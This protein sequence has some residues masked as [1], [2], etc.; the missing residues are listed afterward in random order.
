[1][2]FKKLNTIGGWISFVIALIVYTATVESSV[3]LWDC[4]EFIS[5]AYKLQVVHPPGA[6]LFLMIGRVFSFLAFGNVENVAFWINMLSVISSAACVMFTF[7]ITTHFAAKMVKPGEDKR[8]LIILAAGAVAALTN[9]FID[10]FWFSAVEAEVYALSSFFTALSFWAL[11]KWDVSESK[12]ADRWLVFIAYLVGLALGTHMLNLLII[13]VVGIAYYF[14]NSAKKI[15]MKGAFKALVISALGLGIVMKLIYPGIPWLVSRMDYFFVNTLSL[16]FY[17]GAL[18]SIVFIAALAIFL[19]K[20]TKGKYT[21]NLVVL[22]TL[23]VVL[24]YSSYSMVIIRSLANPTIDMNDPEDP[25][26]FYGYITREQYGDRPLAYGPYFNSQPTATEPKGKKVF[27]S[28]SIYQEGEERFEYVY[29]KISPVNGQNQTTIF[30]RMGGT[31]RPNDEIGYRSWSGMEDVT[32]EIQI[33]Q[34]KANKTAQDQEEIKYLESQLPSF[35]NNLSFFFNYQLGHMYKRYFFWN[36]V[37]RFNNQ[38]GM[39][40]SDLDGAWYSGTPIDNVFGVGSLDGLPKAMKKQKARNAYYF[41][42]FILGLIGLYLHFKKDLKGFWLVMSLFLFTG[43]ILIVYLNPPP[44][45]PRE[46]DY[47]LVGSFQTFCIWVGLG[48][49]GVIQFLRKYLKGNAAIAG[50][51][52]CIL[53]VPVNMGYQNWDDHDRSGR[54]IGKNSAQNFLNNLEPNAVLICNGDNDTYPL[55]YLQ[56]VEGVRTDVR[57]INMSLLPTEWYSSVLLDKVMKSEPL[58]MTLTKK[59]L[60]TGS[61]ENG[62]QINRATKGYMDID[63]A[64]AKVLETNKAGSPVWPSPYISIPTYKSG[65][66]E[67]GIVSQ[68]DLEKAVDTIRFGIGKSYVTKGDILLYNYIAENAKSGWKRPLYFTAVSGYNFNGLNDYLQLEGLVYKFVPVNGGRSGS[69]PANVNREKLYDNLV[70][71]YKYYG[72]KEN[73]NFFL[74]DK[75]SYVPMQMQQWGYNLAMSYASQVTNYERYKKAYDAGQNPPPVAGYATVKEYL[76]SEAD[77]TEKA[78]AKA[79][80]VLNKMVEELP[81]PQ[82]IWNREVLADFGLTYMILGENKKGELLLKDAVEQNQEFFAYYT[83][84]YPE[85]DLTTNRQLNNCYRTASNILNMLN[86]YGFKDLATKYDKVLKP[87]TVR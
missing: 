11:I 14:K 78:R 74:D 18:F 44:Y 35:G 80:Q 71:Q 4:G 77:A 72:M 37:G 45:E 29:D 31:G 6:P 32:Q 84:R 33:L 24:G 76:D 21:W 82:M 51:A 59:D 70:N 63:E 53:L 22:S 54:L 50:A 26:R 75:A 39:N 25:Y 19:I 8:N 12:Y 23:F 10:T 64:M 38:Q 17:S 43:I 83:K 62:I 41:L 27:K 52:A 16:P 65:A 49:I 5:A 55:W 67:A 85:Q 7:W 46:R 42:P 2:N 57:I 79:L 86:S 36:F 9:T 48:V 47:S 13:P 87:M 28:D 56:N 15:S 1:M 61:L 81:Q 69:A 20:K 30:P 73:K 40:S 68:G 58:P 60:Q 34:Q 3:S 66:I